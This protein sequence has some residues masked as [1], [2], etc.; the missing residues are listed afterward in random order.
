MMDILMSQRLKN[1][2]ELLGITLIDHVITGNGKYTSL[3]EMGK[4]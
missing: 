4:F 1:A 2:G 3:R